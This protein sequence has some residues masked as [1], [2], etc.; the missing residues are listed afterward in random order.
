MNWNTAFGVVSLLGLSLASCSGAGEPSV[1]EASDGEQAAELSRA[2]PSTTALLTHEHQIRDL[3]VEDGEVYW[4]SAAVADPNQP[5]VSTGRVGRISKQGGKAHVIASNQHGGGAVAV[6]GKN[7]YWTASAT[8]NGTPV[9]A[10]FSAPRAGGTAVRFAPTWTGFV[11][12]IYPGNAPMDPPYLLADSERV[13]ALGDGGR[14]YRIPIATQTPEFIVQGANH[15]SIALSSGEMFESECRTCGGFVSETSKKAP[16]VNEFQGA[17]A[18]TSFIFDNVCCVWSMAVS[19]SSLYWASVFDGIV[20]AQLN[21]APSPAGAPSTLVPPSEDPNDAARWIAV[22][23]SNLYWSTAGGALRSVPQAG[24]TVTTIVA[25]GVDPD[26]RIAAD[27]DSV[28]WVSANATS[29]ERT[30]VR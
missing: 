28:Y 12:G 26:T 10:I 25:S 6:N 15:T 22:V 4:I 2:L 17:G 27:S 19:H 11:P 7:V 16:S 9:P 24:G 21:G 5:L 13:Y 18:A 14:L 23:G 8:N 20:S 30:R 1:G 3:A 29:I